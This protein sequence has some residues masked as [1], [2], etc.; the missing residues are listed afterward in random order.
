M[1]EIVSKIIF[2]LAV[3][4]LVVN[5][6]LMAVKTVIFIGRAIAKND[7]SVNFRANLW[8]IGIATALITL[9]L[10]W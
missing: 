6:L 10:I 5:L 8:H 1:P 4:A 9:Y 7:A 2:I 3:V